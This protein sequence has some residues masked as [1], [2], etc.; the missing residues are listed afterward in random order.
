M[1]L[2]VQYLTSAH[3][4]LAVGKGRE[5]RQP[6]CGYVRVPGTSGPL[7]EGDSEVDGGIERW[8]EIW[9]CVERSG[10]R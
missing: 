2:K 8:G 5:R 6:T 4:T 7:L 10:D 1:R 9:R 3:N